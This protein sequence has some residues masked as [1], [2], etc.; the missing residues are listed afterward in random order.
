MGI[1]TTVI[2]AIG[3]PPF[4]YRLGQRTHREIRLAVPLQIENVTETRNARER[5][6]REAPWVFSH[7]PQPIETV[8]EGMHVL[9]EGIGKA[10]SFDDLNS[11]LAND[12]G[13]T[14]E[15]FT[16]MRELIPNEAAANKFDKSIDRVLDPFVRYGLLDS[17][18]IPKEAKR[19]ASLI[20]VRPV[21]SNIKY[22][23]KLDAVFLPLLPQDEGGALQIASSGIQGWGGDGSQDPRSQTSTDADVR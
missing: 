4:A 18:N 2:L 16:K 7:N 20:E 11:V 12:W 6:A 13:L 5:A 14:P 21:G 3:G 1:A 22:L 8:R 19:E 17:A 23:P 10:K 15:L 9:A